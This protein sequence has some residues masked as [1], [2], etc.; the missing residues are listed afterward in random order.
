M[1]RGVEPHT[2]V[3][4]LA[5]LDCDDFS[6]ITTNISIGIQAGERVLNYDRVDRMHK[7]WHL[8]FA[9]ALECCCSLTRIAFTR[10]TFWPIFLPQAEALATL[11]VGQQQR[12]N[13]L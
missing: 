12:F 8:F 5:G 1:D 9:E 11:C 10:G 7:P 3:A 4:A 6:A 13:G 2:V